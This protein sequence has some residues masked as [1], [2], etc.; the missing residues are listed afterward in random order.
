VRRRSLGPDHPD[1]LTSMNNLAATMFAQRKLDDA[2]AMQEDVLAR[3]RRALG[4]EHPDTLS[5]RANLAATLRDQGDIGGA[6]RLYEDVLAAR[7]RLLGEDH[8]ETLATIES[9][10]SVAPPRTPTERSTLTERI[11][12]FFGRGAR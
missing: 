1:L 6:R 2:R 12:G 10:R 5:A 7:R 4:D 3:R 9:L 8:P 11:L